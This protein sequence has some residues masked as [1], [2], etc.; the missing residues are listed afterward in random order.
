MTG[1]TNALG[2]LFAQELLDLDTRDHSNGVPGAFLGTN[3]AASAN[4]PVDNDHLV[5]AVAGVM[6]VVNFIDTIDGTKVYAPFTPGAPI[7]VNPGFWPRSTRALRSL[8]HNA[9][10]TF[11]A[12]TNYAEMCTEVLTSSGHT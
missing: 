11:L 5:C 6:R 3:G 10:A 1:A 2:D 12:H 9:P 4:V 8:R 7:D